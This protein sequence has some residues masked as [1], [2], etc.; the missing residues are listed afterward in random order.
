M[1]STIEIYGNQIIKK[2]CY[3]DKSRDPKLCFDE[4]LSNTQKVQELGISPKLL[5]FDS[6]N[7]TLIIEKINGITL[8]DIAF[9]FKKNKKLNANEFY[10]RY[11][12]PCIPL[13]EKLLTKLDTWD[14][15]LSNILFDGS[16]FYLIDFDTRCRMT[17][18]RI[19]S[20]LRRDIESICNSN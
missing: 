1:N 4:E 17:K 8:E 6:I 18:N 5:G 10:D 12:I 3:F 11:I 19:L 20:I 16:K 2:C 15:N 13:F 14:P 7:D 9:E